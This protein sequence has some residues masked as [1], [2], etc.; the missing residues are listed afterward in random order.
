MADQDKPIRSGNGAGNGNG[1]QVLTREAFEDATAY[2]LLT[3]DITSYDRSGSGSSQMGG[4]GIGRV[5]D[6]AIRD[7]LAWRPK[8]DDPKGFVSALTQAFEL[9]QVEGHTEWKWVQRSYA[10]DAELGAVTGAQASI[11]ARARSFLDQSMPL[12]NG[13]K[14][15]RPDFDPEDTE[16]A[17]AIATSSLTEL[18]N[19][20]GQEGGPRVT[21][22]DQLFDLLL[23]RKDDPNNSEKI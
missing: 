20:L 10:I 11:Y 17:R 22:V 3:D 13:L 21:R 14:P 2:P 8:D 16:A 19:E 23:G 15:L 1:A 7:V 5:V 9:Y 12:L 18:V 6:G 4:S